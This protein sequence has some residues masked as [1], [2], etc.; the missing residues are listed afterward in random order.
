MKYNKLVR[1]HIPDI[2]QAK[3]ER[4]ISHTANEVE[5]EQKLSEKLIEEATEFAHDPSVDEL[6]DVLEVIDAI[7][8]HRNFNSEEVTRVKLEKR[9][10]RG[11]FEKR[12]ILDES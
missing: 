6:V 10:K 8:A 11:G 5:Y 3:G 2:I 9:D 1:D 12:I 7:I 4:V